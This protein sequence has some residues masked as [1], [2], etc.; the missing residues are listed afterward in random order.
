MRR[1][2]LLLLILP[3]AGCGSVA[4]G[5]AAHCA[6][7][8]CVAHTDGPLG[9]DY[10]ATN[11][12]PVPATIVLIFRSV[13]NL[14]IPRGRRVETVVPPRTRLDLAHLGK[15]VS[16]RPVGANIAIQIDLGSSASSGD[17]DFA[18]AMPFGGDE[19]RELVQGFGGEETHLA[20]M[21]YSLD[22][23]MPVGTPVLAAREGTVLLTQD[24]FTEGGTDPELLE[25]SNLV[26]IAHSD[27]TMASYGHLSK[28][29]RVR[30]GDDVPEGGLLG[31]S[32]ATGFAG[33]PHLHFHVG[34]RMLGEPGRTIPIKMRDRRGHK[35]DLTVGS[36][37]VPA[38]RRIR[39]VEPSRVR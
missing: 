30:R 2:L 33:Q 32:G 9:R 15:L 27:G 35:V 36:Y 11:R 22:F 34:S 20:S 16:G 17:A 38:E 18:Y 29:V 39:G 19:P 5:S 23:A 14:R 7:R 10:T 25:R 1:L 13:E 12:E 24:G 21:H 8:V 4:P 28:G 26:V 37:V 6:W 3:L 31:Y